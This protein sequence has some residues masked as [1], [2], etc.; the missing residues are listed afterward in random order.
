MPIEAGKYLLEG[1]TKCSVEYFRN[2][3]DMMLQKEH[4]K[5]LSSGMSMGGDSISKLVKIKSVVKLANISLKHE[6]RKSV[7][8]QRN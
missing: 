2:P 3:F 5:Q 7:V 1:L 4:V 8:F 6:D